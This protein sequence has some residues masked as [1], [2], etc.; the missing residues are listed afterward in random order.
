MDTA[1]MLK[2]AAAHKKAARRWDKAA[3]LH[4]QAFRAI[5]EAEA[6]ENEIGEI[7]VD[8]LKPLHKRK[9]A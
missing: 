3:R 5:F 6:I 9:P 8:T 4:A 7:E 2:K 1:T